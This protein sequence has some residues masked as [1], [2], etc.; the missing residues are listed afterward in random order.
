MIIS[1]LDNHGMSTSNMARWYTDS[2][3][4]ANKNKASIL[5]VDPPCGKI[6]VVAKWSV[7]VALPLAF[8]ESCGQIYLCDLGLPQKLYCEAGL[9]MYH[10]PFA[11][12]FVIPLHVS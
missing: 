6:G 1:A 12:K 9:S 10:S 7:A 2:V 3:D 11:H 8:D 5:A 4:W